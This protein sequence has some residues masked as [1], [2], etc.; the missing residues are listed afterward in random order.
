[1]KKKLTVLPE[2]FGSAAGSALRSQ[3]LR[4]AR[5]PPQWGLASRRRAVMAVDVAT[6]PAG[7]QFA[8][9]IDAVAGLIADVRELRRRVR[10][11]HAGARGKKALVAT[12]CTVACTRPLHSASAIAGLPHAI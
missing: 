9:H 4:F 6:G 1:M 3:M 7:S 10:L 2:A 11:L 12:S 5:A 8:G